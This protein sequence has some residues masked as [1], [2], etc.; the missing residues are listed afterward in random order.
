MPYHEYYSPPGAYKD[1][2]KR[3]ENLRWMRRSS[4]SKSVASNVLLVFGYFKKL[5]RVYW[6]WDPIETVARKCIFELLQPIALNKIQ[7]GCNV[8]M[9][10]IQMVC[11]G[12]PYG[13]IL[14]IRLHPHKLLFEEDEADIDIPY[15]H[16]VL[17]LIK[18]KMILHY[19]F[20]WKRT[21][22]NIFC[23]KSLDVPIS[24]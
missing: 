19:H 11:Q 9:K 2:M 21:Q 17:A 20:S 13:V 14:E 10:S 16:I 4:W 6:L 18:G 5:T 3:V 23:H 7:N 22:K 15:L 8:I 24:G 12:A 1:K